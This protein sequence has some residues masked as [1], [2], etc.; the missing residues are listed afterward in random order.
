MAWTIDDLFATSPGRGRASAPRTEVVGEG[1]DGSQATQRSASGRVASPNDLSRQTFAEIENKNEMSKDAATP[2]LP[3][4][5]KER[6]DE[7]ES[8]LFDVRQDL[9]F[10]KIGRQRYS[11]NTHFKGVGRDQ[12]RASQEVPRNSLPDHTKEGSSPSSAQDNIRRGKRNPGVLGYDLGN[13][14]FSGVL[15]ESVE[16]SSQGDEQLIGSSLRKPNQGHQADDGSTADNDTL[17]RHWTKG[18][19]TAGK[20]R[21]DRVRFD[22]DS[23][24]K[25]GTLPREG[26]D[27]SDSD[28]NWDKAWTRSRMESEWGRYGI[29]ADTSDA[30]GSRG[31]QAIEQPSSFKVGISSM[32]STPTGTRGQPDNLDPSASCPT[33][34]SYTSFGPDAK[35]EDEGSKKGRRRPRFKGEAGGRSSGPIVFLGKGRKSSLGSNAQGLVKGSA[36]QEKGEDEGV[37]DDEGFRIDGDPAAPHRVSTTQGVCEDDRGA[38]KGSVDKVARFYGPSYGMR[39]RGYSL[40]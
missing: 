30:G 28:A 27:D 26:F 34:P 40:D 23:F 22:T 12:G 25:K 4:D 7:I 15:R 31:G 1:E 14:T 6:T 33:H 32:P 9:K 39:M 2:A 38:K 8:L 35:S 16:E 21:T 29:G 13:V 24:K 19:S 18:K 10:S 37:V 5:S 11:G 20:A 3:S 36:D 17:N